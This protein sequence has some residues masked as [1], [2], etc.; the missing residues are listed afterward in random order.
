M[1]KKIKLKKIN[2]VSAEMMKKLA[3]FKCGLG[4]R[5]A[6]FLFHPKDIL[7]LYKKGFH[8][9]LPKSHDALRLHLF[10]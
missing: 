3:L 2:C 8:Y 4:A 9:I 10:Y 5:R 6:F 1:K 7:I